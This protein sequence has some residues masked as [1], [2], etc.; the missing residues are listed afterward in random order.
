MSAGRSAKRPDRR[1]ESRPERPP[2]KR[3]ENPPGRRPGHPPEQVK[4][5]GQ[6]P[7]APV[8]DRISAGG[9]V[10][11]EGPSGPEVAIVAVQKTR[12]WQLPKGVIDPGETPEIAAVREVR[13]EAGVDAEI[14]APVETIE[15][16]FAG[17]EN[18]RKVRLHKR[19]HFFLMRYKGGDVSRHDDEVVEA[20][21][22]DVPD[23]LRMLAFKS[24]RNVLEKAAGMF[25]DVKLPRSRRFT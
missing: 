3:P 21:W 9:V 24:E 2:V 6:R 20:R 19:V 13:E 23:A 18:G 10:L 7:A 4:Q 8:I 5:T 16:W 22:V 15:Y 25:E 14:V 17:T 11:R 12:R 1:A